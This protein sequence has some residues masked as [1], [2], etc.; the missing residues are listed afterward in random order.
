MYVKVKVLAGVRKE[1]VSRI[2][3]TNFEMYVK[4]PAKQNL[5]NQR[6]REI[7]ANEM[8]VNPK[9]LKL[10]TGHHSPSKIFDVDLST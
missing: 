8:K 9:K 6:V 2:D 4:E 1:K 10:V 3:A 5:A 7:L